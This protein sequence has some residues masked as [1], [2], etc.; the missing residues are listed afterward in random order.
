M[1][2]EQSSAEQFLKRYVGLAHSKVHTF[3][4]KNVR[5]AETGIR[6]DLLQAAK[7][8]ILQAQ[9]SFDPTIGVPELV[10]VSMKIEYAILQEFNRI[11]PV[12]LQTI[13]KQRRLKEDRQKLESLFG[14]TVTKSEL[15]EFLSMEDEELDCLLQEMAETITTDYSLDDLGISSQDDSVEDVVHMNE[16]LEKIRKV[17]ATLSS[18]EQAIL[19]M[20]Y[21]EGKSLRATGEVFGVTKQTIA[22]QKYKMLEKLRKALAADNVHGC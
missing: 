13:A 22:E 11:N 20:L 19:R 4:S 21:K 7:I 9:S 10:Y 3:L 17:T 15:A 1:S 12:S 16:V 5:L 2:L 8:G 18:R 14:R 6:D